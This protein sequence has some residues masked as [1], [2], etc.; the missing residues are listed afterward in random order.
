MSENKKAQ[1]KKRSQV[2]KKA[3]VKKSVQVRI[4]RDVKDVQPKAV[5]KFEYVRLGTTMVL[6]AGHFDIVQ[7]RTAI[8]DETQRTDVKLFVTNRFALTPDAA[9]DLYEVAQFIYKDLKENGFLDKATR[10]M[11]HPS[12]TESEQVDEEEDR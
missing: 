3:H 10:M 4:V 5:D 7:L 1:A 12:T 11:T 6:E 2:K 9:L 8:S